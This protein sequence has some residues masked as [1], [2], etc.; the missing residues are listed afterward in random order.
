MLLL[1]GLL[2]CNREADARAEA[3]LLLDK[4]HAL[5]GDG[6]LSER[7]AALDGLRALPLHEA[8]HGHTRDL[9]HSA[10]LQLLEAE[11]AQVAARKSLDEA[12]AAAKP[13]GA[14]LSPERGQA[15]AAELERSN[16]ALD[17]ARKAFPVC[18]QA[19]LVLT[20]EAR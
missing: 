2:A 18:E 8:E 19:T 5:S 10:H 6:T 14:G 11:V 3:K 4:L 12:A 13:G 17:A 20:Q 16:A 15:I 9:C 1:L 7:K